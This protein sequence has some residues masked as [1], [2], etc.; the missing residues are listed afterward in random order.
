MRPCVLAT[1]TKYTLMARVAASAMSIPSTSRAENA[2]VA[3]R[4]PPATTSAAQQAMSLVSQRLRVILVLY[5]M[6]S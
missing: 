5:V 4:I 1:S 3:D 2:R 6:E